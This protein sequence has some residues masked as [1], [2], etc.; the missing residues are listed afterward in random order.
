MSTAVP[1]PLWPLKSCQVT[2]TAKRLPLRQSSRAAVWQAV[3]AGRA[4]RR[5]FVAGSRSGAAA[6]IGGAAGGEAGLAGGETTLA[7]G[8]TTAKA[9]CGPK[10]V[11]SPTLAI[12][13][14]GL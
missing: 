13:P 11:V 5:V 14:A 10:A 3:L 7:G 1:W 8:R 9:P 12:W 6:G 2:V 4:S